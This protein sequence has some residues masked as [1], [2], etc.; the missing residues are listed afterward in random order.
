M[1]SALH[2]GPEWMRSKQ[3][4]QA[5]SQNAPSPPPAAV[6]TGGTSYSSILNPTP[7]P[8]PTENR[9][10]A[11]P[12]KYSKEEII[13]VWKHGGGRNGLGLEVERWEG[14]VREVAGEPICLRD[15]GEVEKKVCSCFYLEFLVPTDSSPSS[16]PL[17]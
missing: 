5:R 3:P 10:S 13:Q 6:Q 8:P 1:A 9:D 2:F 15:L 4:T 11:H 12:F 7:P 17:P 14:V 16:S